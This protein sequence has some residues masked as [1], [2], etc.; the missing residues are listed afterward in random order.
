MPQIPAGDDSYA[1]VCPKYK[2]SE[3]ER[4][5]NFEHRTVKDT[6]MPFSEPIHGVDGRQITEAFVPKH[7]P[8]LVGIR[9]CNRNKALWGED[10]LEW[11][12]ER[13]LSPLP[14]SVTEAK[15]PGVYSNL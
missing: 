1:R 6:V 2:L 10:A 9:A 5:T 15:I 14:E 7:T 3:R 13:W 11:K 4:L 8:I 12:P